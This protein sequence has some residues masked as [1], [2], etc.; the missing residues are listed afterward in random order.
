MCYTN[1]LESQ[2]TI[3]RQTDSLKIPEATTPITISAET[4]TTRVNILRLK[5]G[6]YKAKYERIKGKCQHKHT[7][8]SNY[9]RRFGKFGN[10]VSISCY[11]V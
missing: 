1:K 5:A 6:P 9:L 10:F 7:E 8:H 4:I 2:S 3:R 11:V